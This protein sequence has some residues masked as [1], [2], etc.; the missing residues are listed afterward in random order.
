MFNNP[1]RNIIEHGKLKNDINLYGNYQSGIYKNISWEMKRNV[2]FKWWCGYILT[3]DIID[4]S[5]ISEDVMDKLDEA[6]YMGMTSSF[7]FDCAHCEDYPCIDNGTY[8]DY[9]FVLKHIKDMIDIIILNK[10]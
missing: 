5:D 6:A 8:K 7:G 2:L 3:S 1:I 4:L 9:N 10:I